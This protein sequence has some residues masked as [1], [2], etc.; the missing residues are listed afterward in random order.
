MFNC[1]T[2]YEACG[3]LSELNSQDVLVKL[4]ER[5]PHKIIVQFVP[6]ERSALGTFS[7]LRK[8]VDIAAKDAESQYGKCL[9][10]AKTDKVK[11]Q[12][13]GRKQFAVC[14]SSEAPVENNSQFIVKCVLCSGMHRLWHCKEFKAKPLKERNDFVWSQK[15]CFRCL[16]SRHLSR[17]C[18]SNLR[19]K[20]CGEM[21]HNTL[22]HHDIKFSDVR[23]KNRKSDK[24][25]EQ[26]L[27]ASGTCKQSVDGTKL[28]K[29]VPVKEWTTDP[30]NYV[31]TY[32]FLHEGSEASVCTKALAR[33]LG[34]KLANSKMR[35]CTNNAVTN[36][37][38]V[39][40]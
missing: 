20:I 33:R 5:V 19:C 35:M 7:E 8:L 40:P 12:T 23:S 4:F 27:V 31:L 18:Q 1:E 13:S 14:A 17:E 9:F 11:K 22:L 21:S 24:T 26:A 29:V 34:A 15:L 2:V 10:Q 36:V 25:S 30:A 32:C 16:Q 38:L 37:D 6:L 39:L 28:H 3:R